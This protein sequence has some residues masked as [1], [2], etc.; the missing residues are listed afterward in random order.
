MGCLEHTM[1]CVRIIIDSAESA[2]MNGKA[3]KL[4]KF[5]ANSM[6]KTLRKNDKTARNEHKKMRKNRKTARGA[7]WVATPVGGF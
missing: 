2:K 3:N 6:S 4:T 5:E 1:S 7:A